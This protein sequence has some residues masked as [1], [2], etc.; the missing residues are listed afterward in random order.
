MYCAKIYRL[1]RWNGLSSGGGWRDGEMEGTTIYDVFGCSA[2]DLQLLETLVW[3]G[4][5]EA[6]DM[7]GF[8]WISLYVL[9]FYK[10]CITRGGA[11]SD[12]LL[13]NG[14]RA[15]AVRFPRFQPI[16]TMASEMHLLSDL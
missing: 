1:P 11:S 6:G 14:P 2:A 12:K 16:N 4:M 5:V 7:K 13:L 3:S 10:K 9:C 15:S 8:C